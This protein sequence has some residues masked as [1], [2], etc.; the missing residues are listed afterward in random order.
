MVDGGIRSAGGSFGHGGFGYHW[1]AQRSLERVAGICNGSDRRLLR[2]D[3]DAS[4]ERAWARA[5][6][7]LTRTGMHSRARVKAAPYRA[8]RVTAS[9][10]SKHPER[11]Y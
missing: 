8:A 4:S 10:G 5:F 6:C 9:R 7:R 11:G 2:V 1:G 3:F